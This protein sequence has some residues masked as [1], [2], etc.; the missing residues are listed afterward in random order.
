MSTLGRPIGAGRECEVFE[1]EPGRVVRV[2]RRQGVGDGFG[3]ERV[4]M[5][6]ARDAGFPVPRVYDLI[7]VDGRAAMVLDRVDGSDAFT[8]FAARPWELPQLARITGALQADLHRVRAPDGLPR[9]VEVA[10]ELLT[11]PA[12]PGAVQERAA[13]RLVDLVDGDRL[14]HGDF[15]PGNVLLGTDGPVVIDW[16]NAVV[17]P[18]AADLAM[19]MIILSVGSPGE[20]SLVERALVA[21]ARRLYTRLHLKSA[22][23][24]EPSTTPADVTAWVPV[25]AALRL[26]A[27]IGG[28]ARRT[29]ASGCLVS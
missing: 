7:E 25:M 12:I 13:A 27:G 18:P 6:A 21:G 9:L 29:I 10:A 19:T 4:A 11:E 22:L 26:R 24:K 5:Q 15:H 28:G 14:L 16:P 1:G 20:V 8:R 23:A 3:A 2:A 17:G